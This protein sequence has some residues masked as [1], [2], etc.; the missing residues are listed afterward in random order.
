[1]DPMQ[2]MQSLGDFWGKSGQSLFQSQQTLLKEMSTWMEKAAKGELPAGG[3]LPGAPGSDA[4]GL[5]AASQQYSKLWASALELSGT[6]TRN[7]QSGSPQDAVVTE[8]LGRIFDPRNWFSATDEVDEALQ[9]M[10][11]GPRLSDL[12]DVERKVLVVFNAW[13]ALRRRTMEHNT[14]MLEAW[15]QAAGTFAKT[16]NERAERGEKFESWREVLDAWVDIANVQLLHTQRSDDFLQS[17]REVLK[18]ST[19]LRL[20]QQEIAGFYSEMFGYPT[21]AE[22]DDI[23]KT[24]TDLKREVRALRREAR[25][26]LAKPVATGAQ[27]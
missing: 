9:R 15:M 13:L 5:T 21:R 10:A 22:L 17:Q 27:A 11:E 23:N 18:A 20:A 4:A 3:M 6:V 26:S 1:M 14:L 2:Y 12:W 8:T 24:V 16:M 25:R 7:L 19:D